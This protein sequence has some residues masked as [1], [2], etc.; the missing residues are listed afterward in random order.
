MQSNDKVLKD[1]LGQVV[2]MDA[3]SEARTKYIVPRKAEVGG[4]M[5]GCSD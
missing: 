3:W 2:E 5:M 4:V 1:L